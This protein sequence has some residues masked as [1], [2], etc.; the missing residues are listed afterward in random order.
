MSILSLSHPISPFFVASVPD[1]ATLHIFPITALVGLHSLASQGNTKTSAGTTNTIKAPQPPTPLSVATSQSQWAGPVSTVTPQ[2]HWWH[3]P[4]YMFYCKQLQGPW[5]LF[6]FHTHSSHL[7]VMV[8]CSVKE[9]YNYHGAVEL[10]QIQKWDL[11]Q[12]GC[13]QDSLGGLVLCLSSTGS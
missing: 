11:N 13:K 7:D 1:A 10:M 4:W 12:S 9:G 6:G 3:D 8:L 5:A 2:V